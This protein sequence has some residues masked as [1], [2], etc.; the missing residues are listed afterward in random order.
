MRGSRSVKT[1]SESRLHEELKRRYA[2]IHDG[3]VEVT[4]E[5]FQVDVLKGNVVVEV[6]VGKL[7]A[8]RRKLQTLTD[9]GYSVHVVLP[10]QAM[11]TTPVRAKDSKRSH[12]RTYRRKASLLDVFRELVY[13]PDLLSIPGVKLEILL[14]HEQ[15]LSYALRETVWRGGRPRSRLLEG[16]NRDTMIVE[17]LAREVIETKWELLK[18]LPASLPSF[19]TNHDLAKAAKISYSLASRTTYTLT[20]AG[21]L[22]RTGREGRRDVYTAQS[23][24]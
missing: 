19:F 11:V 9:H 16:F 23:P 20:R 13:F 21:V 4:V 3:R 8:L 24:S 5:G 22:R 18:L 17:A 12:L 15:R 14:L 6:Q 10:I 2:K 7:G 1:K